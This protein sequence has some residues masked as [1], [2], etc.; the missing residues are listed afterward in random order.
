MFYGKIKKKKP[1]QNPSTWH[2]DDSTLD[3]FEYG[4][5]CVQY[6]HHTDK[7]TGYEDCLYL[8]VFVPGNT[9]NG[10]FSLPLK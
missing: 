3:A 9:F 5:E 1:P 7:T 4:N 2:D 6:N 10:F 8:N